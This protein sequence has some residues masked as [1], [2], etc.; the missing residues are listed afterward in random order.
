ME[1]PT[2]ALPREDMAWR[3]AFDAERPTALADAAPAAA[4]GCAAPLEAVLAAGAE[5]LKPALPALLMA[6]RLASDAARAL[7]L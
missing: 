3:L 5:L 2:P 7:P 4:L 6:R 1:L